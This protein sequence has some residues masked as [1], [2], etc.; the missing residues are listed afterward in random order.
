MSDT[1]KLVTLSRLKALLDAYGILPEHWPEEERTAATALIETS[2]AARMLVEE[3]AAL[4]ALLDAIPE[5]EVSAAI[6]SRVRS[7]PFPAA[8]R[9]SNGIFTRLLNFL[10]PQTPRGWQG[11]VAMAGIL[12]IVAGIG[13]S[14]MVTDLVGSNIGV[15]ATATQNT[16]L[17]ISVTDIGETAGT[18]LALDGDAISLTGDDMVVVDNDNTDQ[19]QTDTG[20]FTVAGIP[21]Y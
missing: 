5:P 1:E 18:S 15:V 13:V 16:G 2:P 14:P 20:E 21:L 17:E 7:L 12:G 9:K 3:A 10:R 4:D 11:A 6:A 19:P 8:A